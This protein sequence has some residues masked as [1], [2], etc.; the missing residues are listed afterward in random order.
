MAMV[1]KHLIPLVLV[2]SFNYP[3]SQPS[4]RT[5]LER[6]GYTTLSSHED[7]MTYL[8]SLSKSSPLISMKIIGESVEGRKIAAL[9]FSTDKIIGTR[10][11]TK[12]MVL[13]FCQQHGDEP[14]GKEAALVLAREITQSKNDLL[15]KLDLILIPQMNPDGSEKRKRRNGNDMDLNRNHAILSEPE[16]RAL[17]QL[18]YKWM[19]EVTLDVHEYS[20]VT[21]TWVNHGFIKNAE[22]QIGKVSNVN[23]AR[24]IYDFSAQVFIPS[25]DETMKRAG[26]TFHEYLVGTP[27]EGSRLRYSTTAI[28]DGRNSLGIYNTFSFIQ[29]GIQF[30]DLIT[31]I[32]HRVK[33]QLTSLMAFLNTIG[34]NSEDILQIIKTSRQQILENDRIK[35]PRTS[36]QMDYYPDSTMMISDYPIFDLLTWQKEERPL[37]NFQGKVRVRKSIEKPLA[38]VISNSEGRLLEILSRHRIE[39]N[40][41]TEKHILQVDAYQ[42]LHVTSYNE[43]ELDV[44]YADVQLKSILREFEKGSMIIY[45]SQPAG[46]LIPLLLE[47][48][49]RFNLCGESS[50][51]KYN[52]SEYLIE[53]SEYPIY[54]LMEQADLQQIGGERN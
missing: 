36:I 8:E 13:I 22:V 41:M 37:E 48:Q 16:T 2:L 40:P 4:F 26:F 6:S 52:F 1:K 34:E 46:N 11:D 31:R 15:Q 27:F 19:P 12:P 44:P 14:S 54:R 28:N 25:I 39:M 7:M 51:R 29:E 49:S 43:E 21:K 18:F 24:Q 32:D 17:H 42:I 3:F 23:I 33:T 5:P 20:A 9:F 50:G 38:Y 35:A 30:G 47:P 45:L 53:N 10:R